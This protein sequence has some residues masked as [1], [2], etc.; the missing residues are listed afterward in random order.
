MMTAQGEALMIALLRAILEAL[1]EGLHIT[2]PSFEELLKTTDA[3]D[4]ATEPVPP[5]SIA[6][7]PNATTQAALGV[8]VVSGPRPA[9]RAVA[10]VVKLGS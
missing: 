5:I 10:P 7:S 3:Y 6:V 9:T 8:A 2:V 1:G 4:P